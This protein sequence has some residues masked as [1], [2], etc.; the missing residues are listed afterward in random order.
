MNV[1]AKLF[2]PERR[3][4]LVVMPVRIKCHFD[5]GMTQ[6]VA[7]RSYRG[8][9]ADQQGCASM[10]KA[11]TS[12]TL[13]TKLFDSGIQVRTSKVAVVKS[14][15]ISPDKDPVSISLSF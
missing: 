9:K 15:A 14:V 12:D 1:T 13:E 11:V 2:H 7:D 5:R 8:A 3:V 6:Y 10:T 4:I